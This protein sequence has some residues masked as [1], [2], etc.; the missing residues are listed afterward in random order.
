MVRSLVIGA[1]AV[2]VMAACAADT[3]G[4]AD[5]DAAP[6]PRGII[7]GPIGAWAW[8]DIPGAVCA[9]GTPTGL[10]V[11]QGTGSQVV[12]YLSPG[13]A[14]LDEGCSIGTPSQRRDGG[15]RAPELAACVAGDCDGGITFPDESLFSRTAESNPFRDATYVFISVCSGDYYI[16][17]TTHAFPTWTATFQGSRNQALFAAELAASFPDA[18]R[19]I[20]T[21]GSAGAV[22]AL[23]NYWQWVAAFSGTR[24]DLIS[25]SFALVVADRPEFR[26]DLH[27]PRVPPACAT[28]ATDYRTVHDFNASIAPP[29]ARLAVVDSEANWTLVLT[30]GSRYTEGLAALQSRLDPHANTR[31]FVA[32]GNV[33]VLVRHALDSAL[34]DVADPE[35]GTHV[36]AEFFARM[37][38][39]D[40]AW[41]SW[42][43]LTSTTSR[44]TQR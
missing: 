36:L 28:C 1:F 25:D 17:D 34:T 31:Y 38:S 30:Q 4:A 37:Q 16:G 39:D 35:A 40:P 12:V 27:A 26:Y 41:E 18:S 13:S 15:F 20:L 3:G 43:C 19:V 42:S 23:L 21:G 22:G 24:V 44:A 6:A 8:Y 33:H 5:V 9:N 10:G 14:C 29:G 7:D 32:N 2:V 11:N